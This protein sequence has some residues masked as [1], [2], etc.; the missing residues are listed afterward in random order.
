[1]SEVIEERW[2]KG[3]VGSIVFFFILIIMMATALPN[4][5]VDAVMLKERKYA[6]ALLSHDELDDIISKTETIYSTLVI[7]SGAKEMISD[8]FMT[9]GGTVKAFEEKVGWWFEYLKGRGIAIQK[10]IYQMI[11]RIVLMAYWLPFFV[12]VVIPA[13][14]AGWMRWHAKRNGFDYSSPF[15]NNNSLLI[16][17]WSV[18]ALLLSILVPI[19]L[20]PLMVS[21]LTI[22]ILP[23][24]LTVLIRNLPKRI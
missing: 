20:P 18:V 3:V 1:M 10:I 13:I 9:R 4:G 11:Y 21:T 15:M 14:Y 5:M 22:I 19:P 2:P 16:L 8:V 17:S 7:E 12:A 6:V 24:V 23:I